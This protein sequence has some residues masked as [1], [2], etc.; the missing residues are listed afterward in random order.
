MNF[1][2]AGVDN[3]VPMRAEDVWKRLRIADVPRPAVEIIGGTSVRQHVLQDFTPVTE[4][5][6]WEL[7]R[8]HWE[9]SGTSPFAEN[10]VP[11]MVNNSGRL[12]TDTAWLLFQNCLEAP[13]QQA[14][15][16]LEVGA[17]CALLA[18][19]TLDAF[20]LLCAQEQR[21]FFDR[22]VY[23][24][25]DGSSRTVQDWHARG[26]FESAAERVRTMVLRAD[27][28]RSLEQQLHAIAADSGGIRAVLCNYVFDVLP[29][30][31]VRRHGSTVEELH[32]RTLL[33]AEPALLREYTARSLEELQRIV[34]SA[35]PLERAELIP[36][37]SLFD[38]EASFIAASGAVH[39]YLQRA[40][41]L[42]PPRMPV[43]VNMGALDCVA[44]L[45]PFLHPAGFV[46]INDYG[47]TDLSQAG[48]YGAVQRFGRTTAQALN[49]PIFDALVSPAWSVVTPV[50][51]EQRSIHSRL[52]L[53][54]ELPLTRA[55]FQRQFSADVQA[56][57]EAP[58]HE[59][60]SHLAGGRRN[61]ALLAFRTAIERAPGDWRVL[62]EAAEFVGLELRDFA[63]GAELA[64]SALQL[65]PWYSSWLWNV[66]GDCLYCAERQMDAHE[67]YLQAQRIHSHDP[68]TLLNLAYTQ[69]WTGDHAAALQSL[70]L[71]LA[72]DRGAYRERLLEKQSAI[73]AAMDLRRA[74]ETKRMAV[75]A[76]HLQFGEPKEPRST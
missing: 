25:T 44:A 69:A 58:I 46:L 17:G 42:V 9:R 21:D 57:F 19:A 50:S 65:N 35:E 11:F 76:S 75:A 49:F 5:L 68:R 38:V 62:G 10:E 18:H 71:G 54:A 39:P 16:V 67:A 53:R 14:L 6:Q 29:S 56:E 48:G 30:R 2:T 72:C 8:L 52:L 60:R 73:L 7:S 13:P 3:P 32:I 66:L 55:C 70:G 12:A 59:A 45:R 43:L 61:D 27:D 34:G 22:L 24:V 37:I 20:R 63:S 64:R 74:G 51:D 36:L 33:N 40:L 23:V 47:P 41:E 15:V 26:M 1:S 28:E 31:I 4:S